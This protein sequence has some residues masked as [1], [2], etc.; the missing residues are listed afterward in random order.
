MYFIKQFIYLVLNFIAS[1]R[2]QQFFRVQIE[3]ITSF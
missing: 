2:L 3:Q 1:N